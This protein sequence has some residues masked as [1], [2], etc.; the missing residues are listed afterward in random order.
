MIIFIFAFIPLV[1]AEFARARSVPTVEDFFLQS[2]KMPMLMSFFTV[3]A[4]WVSS[5][6][7]FGAPTSF[8]LEGPMYMTCFA[9][10]ILF[11]LLFMIIGRRIWFYGKTAGMIT[12]TDFFDEIYHSKLLNIISTLVLVVFT[13]PYLMIQL[14]AGA[15]I[16][17]TAS[18]G[19]IPW[20]AAGMVFYLVI[21]IY[22]WAGGLRAVAMTDVFYGI[23]TFAVMILCGA[24][25][26]AKTGGVAETFGVIMQR[27]SGAVL[28][29]HGRDVLAPITWICMFIIIPLGALMGPPIWIR[30][31]AVRN[32]S[33]FRLMPLL[34]AVVTIM[35]IGPL[36]TGSAAAVLYPNMHSPNNLI[37]DTIIRNTSV[38][39]GTVLLCGV[40]TSALS[41]ANSQIHALA[42]IYTIDIHRR[43][44]K[45]DATEKTLVST[46]KWSVLIISAAVYVLMLQ[47]PGMIIDTGTVGMGGTA[48]II[49]PTLGALFWN[50]SHPRA[51][52]TGLI[53]GIAIFSAILI[54][55]NVPA[56]HAAMAAL[57]V[58]GA[59]F[60]LLSLF[61]KEN[62]YTCEKI[63]YYREIFRK[64][65]FS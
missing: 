48:Q 56:V 16:V 4:T 32:E 1:I 64:R 34:L 17:E 5:F 25:L 44:V 30:I 65:H 38:I 18:N 52:E 47:K 8:Y 61:L 37:L 28:L 50:K 2:R 60:V 11:G 40:A 3:Y 10:N 19:V 51:A 20:R 26:I 58:N 57:L 14:Y 31:F 42:A 41:T 46:G 49:V 21:I 59:C 54:F 29:G 33:Q 7:F 36:L 39:G 9:W 45:R 12:P 15:C 22:L 6:A 62:R 27:D 43:A 35:Y 23:F 53:L 55:T 63:S 24:I 13:V